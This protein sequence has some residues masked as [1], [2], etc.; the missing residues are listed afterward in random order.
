MSFVPG[1]Q[2]PRNNNDD[3]GE[4][5]VSVPA[6]DAASAT[7]PAPS[8]EASRTGRFYH[9]EIDA[10]RFL[11]FLAV[12]VH[13]AFPPDAATYVGFGFSTGVAAWITAVIR[14]GGFGVDLFLGLSAYLITELLVREHAKR[15]KIDIR[16]FYIRRALR[17]WPLYFAFLA[18]VILILPHL[19]RHEQLSTIQSVGYLTFLGNWT[20]T[21]FGYPASVAAPLWSVSIEEQFYL[22]WPFLLALIGIRRVRGLAL[23]L[24]A[25]ATLTR[26]VLVMQGVGHPGIWCNTFARL[27]AIAGGALLAALLRGGAPSLKGGMRLLMAAGGVFLFVLAAR[28][29]SF[30][31][32]ASLY[33]YPAAAAASLLVLISVLRPMG[34][35]QPVMAS[36]PLLYLGKIS[37]GL[38][39]F[40]L[41]ALAVA[42]RLIDTTMIPGLLGVRFCLALLIAIA[43][44]AGSYRWLEEPFLRLKSRFTYVNSRPVR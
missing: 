27:D 36:R 38:Y 16:A 3:Q 35:R 40:H 28:Y 5:S 2:S 15:G 11:A 43:I 44:A 32:A 7:A 30:D 20:C 22:M 6:G 33:T 4:L 9:P 26:V 12:L 13:H 25:I 8:G 37:Y 19:L 39:V 42:A 18:T 24:L 17:I 41:L 31:G 10:L 23:S 1:L 34:S 14:S 29:G 21:L